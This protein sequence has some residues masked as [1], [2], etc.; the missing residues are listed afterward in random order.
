MSVHV[1]VVDVGGLV[2]CPG[3]T[4]V[5]FMMGSVMVVVVVVDGWMMIGSTV[6][7]LTM[8]SLVLVMVFVGSFVVSST[9]WMLT[10]GSFVV[11]STGWMLAVGFFVVSSTGWMLTVGS[12]VVFFVEGRSMVMSSPHQAQWHTLRRR[13]TTNDEGT[14]TCFIT[15]LYVQTLRAPEPLSAWV[16][17]KS[18]SIKKSQD[19]GR[20]ILY[21]STPENMLLG[22]V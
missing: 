3:R 17:G 13:C 9:G 20:Q 2:V 4:G 16:S 1:D 7:R 21:T 10:V 15:R 11:S 5:A 6:G 14:T 19:M 18:F 8:G 22:G 12:L